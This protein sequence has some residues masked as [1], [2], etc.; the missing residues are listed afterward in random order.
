[1]LDR[2]A[3]G[4]RAVSELSEETKHTAC[5]VVWA[6]GGATVAAF[7]PGVGSIFLGIRVGS[8]LSL[9]RSASGRVFLS[10]MPREPVADVLKRELAEMRLQSA[11]GDEI[12]EKVRREGISRVKDTMMVGLSAVAAP[13]FDHDGRLLYVL[14]ALGQTE[15]FDASMKGATADIVRNKAMELST[16]LG[17]KPGSAKSISLSHERRRR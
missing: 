6:N 12:V 14:T 17:F 10:Y 2:D 4:R 5:L 8:I 11:A 7:D 1:L 13:V 9:L 3:L 16:R 15:S